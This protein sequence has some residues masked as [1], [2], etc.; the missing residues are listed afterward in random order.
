MVLCKYFAEGSQ[1]PRGSQVVFKALFGFFSVSWIILGSWQEAV[2]GSL[3]I[4]DTI[5]LW[6]SPIMR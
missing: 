2:G 1:T 5:I 6:I 3:M 4:F